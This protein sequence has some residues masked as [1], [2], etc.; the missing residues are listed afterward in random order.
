MILDLHDIF[1]MGEDVKIYVM[2]Y[3]NG[4]ICRYFE[5]AN[6]YVGC[7]LAQ[8]FSLIDSSS[9]HVLHEL[10]DIP[11]SLWDLTNGLK[12]FSHLAYQT[13]II[14]SHKP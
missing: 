11:C 8:C 9:L 10:G 5:V 1:P 13:T 2:K 4:L 6:V 3:C 7:V 14:M 12:Q